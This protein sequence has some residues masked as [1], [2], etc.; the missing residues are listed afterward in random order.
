MNDKLVLLVDD[1]QEILT[2]YGLALK[3]AGFEVITAINGAEAV[4]AAKNK[5]PDLIL[6]DLKMPV[7]NGAEALSKI[8][9]D[10]RLKDIKIVFLTAFS[11]PQRVEIDEKFA[12][13]SGALDFI[14]KG[15]SLEE[16]IGK[17]KG[18]L[19]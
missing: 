13:E 16:F 5:N 3:N 14:R 18:Y 15:I 4:E 10:P 19:S 11:D 9:E 8:K 1:E 2:L 12:K 17:V 6:L 7:M